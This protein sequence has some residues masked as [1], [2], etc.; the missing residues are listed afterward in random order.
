VVAAGRGIMMVL[1]MANVIVTEHIIDDK[2]V[3]SWR[4]KVAALRHQTNRVQI[5]ITI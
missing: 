1:S 3:D 2:M 4:I 5:C